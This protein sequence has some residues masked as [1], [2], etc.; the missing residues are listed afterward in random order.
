MPDSPAAHEPE[1]GG[2]GPAE[3]RSEDVEVRVRRSPKYGV[4][5]AIG[6]VLGAVVAWV[7]GSLM[8]PGVDVEGRPV[9]TTPVIGLAIVGGFV[10]GAGIG[11]VVALLVD[12]SL[13]KR[14]RTMV[15]EH[16][17][18]Q[19][20]PVEAQMMEDATDALEAAFEPLEGDAA[21]DRGDGPGDDLG[22]TAQRDRD[23]PDA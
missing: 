19:A 17:H 21:G 22:G 11:G 15:A 8:P 4:F 18:E 7:V 23:R 5:L 13:R 14:T 1:Q 10:V 16:V 9:D 2:A 6:A 12:R 20:P 3:G